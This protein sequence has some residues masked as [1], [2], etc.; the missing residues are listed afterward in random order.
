[1][2]EGD[3]LLHE[4]EENLIV[5]ILL[6]FVEGF[7]ILQVGF[8]PMIQTPH[9]QLIGLQQTAFH[10]SVDCLQRGMTCIHQ[11][12]A[13]DLYRRLTTSLSIQRIPM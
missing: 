8:S 5:G 9:L 12:I 1:M 7:D 2:Q 10:Q 11:L 13:G 3:I 6:G 4:R